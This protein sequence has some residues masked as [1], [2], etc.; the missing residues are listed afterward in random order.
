MHFS[1]F[2]LALLASLISYSERACNNSPKLCSKSYDQI[3]HLGAHDSPFLRDEKNGFSTFGN[4]FFN[5]TVQR[6]AGVRLL[7]A[8]VHVSSQPE[9]KAH[10]LHLCHSSCALFD[11][12][13][14][15]AWL[16]EIRTWLDANPFDIVT[17]VLVNMDSIS[18]VELSASYSQADLAHYG[19][20]PPVIDSASDPSSDFNR[21]WPTLGE[22]I[23]RGE[24]FV[25]FVNP[26]DVD[27]RNAPNLLNE[28]DF[29]W[30]NEYAVTRPED[31]DCE[32][33]R[34]SNKAAM[35]EMEES[36][37][38][39][40]MNHMLYFQQAFGIQT[41]DPRRIGDTN[42]WDRAGGL[43]AHMI[44]CGSEMARQPTFVLV[45][46]FIVG[47]AIASVDIF[48]AVDRQ[49]GRKSVTTEVVEGGPDARVMGGAGRTAGPPTLAL[50]VAVALALAIDAGY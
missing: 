21:T 33:D 1:F 31:F 17:L 46:F 48:N 6:D 40:L 45:D 10:Q 5:T 16:W 4:Q 38:L 14:L 7:S 11:A 23:D 2:L 30:E 50:V 36:G 24:R 15:S 42:S 3:T 12:G 26:L 37:K 35:A 44:R 19:Y 20:V 25:T 27:E 18:A 22:M 28:F 34:P 43:G 49:A 41:P 39:F 29:V 9:M 32:P 8:Q 13:P 47:P